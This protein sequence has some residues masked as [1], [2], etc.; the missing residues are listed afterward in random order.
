M[1]QNLQSVILDEL[2]SLVSSKRGALLSLAL[3]RVTAAAPEVRYPTWNQV[4]VDGTHLK[5][6]EGDRDLTWTNI[7]GY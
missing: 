5:M 6:S 4:Y 2:H 7:I 3:S 1:L